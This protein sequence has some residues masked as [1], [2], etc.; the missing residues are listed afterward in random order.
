MKTGRLLHLVLLMTALAF[1][2]GCGGGSSNG[3]TPPPG[4]TLGI[5]TDAVLPG[6][7]SG[8]S[9]SATLSAS[10]GVG[11]LHWSIA[12]VSSTALYVTGLTIDAN[13]GKLSG[14]VNWGGTAGFIA[15]VTDSS[16]TARTA[17]KGFYITAY[18]PLQTPAPQNATVMEYRDVFP[19]TFSVQGGVAPLKF[20]LTGGSLPP[21]LRLDPGNGGQILG[22][23]ITTGTYP[24]TVTIQ[25]SF[26]PPEV[27]TMQLTVTVIPPALTIAGGSLPATMALNRAFSGKV[28][29]VGGIPPYHFALTAGSL[30][31]GLGT[32]D[33]GGFISGIPN[34][35]GS[36]AFTVQA[37]DSANPVQSASAY[38]AI[39][40]RP[41][42]GRND[43]IATATPIDNGT[44]N[45]SISP[46]ID[47]PIGVPVAGD[48]DYYSL[49]ALGGTTV[50]VET[51]A[52]RWNQSNP[53]D[54]VLEIL[55]ANGAR[56]NTCK[57]PGDTGT[58]YASSCINDDISASP[59]VQDSALDLKVPGASNAGTRFYVHVLDWRGDARPD[60][61]YALTVSGVVAPLAVQTTSLAPAARGLSYSQQ[62][63]SVNGTG[64][65]TWAVI[66][67]ALPPGLSLSSAG[68]IT[69]SATTDGS[70]AFTVQATDSANP[71]QTA[72]T[73]ESI[74]VVEPVK[75]TSSPTLPDACVN[76]AYS[77]AI[78]TSGG[79]PPLQWSF[80]S[81]NWVAIN[82]NQA[83]GV[84]SGTTNVAG[85]FI[86]TLG[87]GDATGH[88]DSQ[89]I[90]LTVKQCP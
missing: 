31:P 39:T 5:T 52:K 46:Y 82:L 6:T 80:M 69:G 38:F 50:H 13:T 63:S 28:I 3:T 86:G 32:M 2:A 90:S 19:L 76:Q 89:Q 36:Y 33:S 44:I 57:Q 54:T 48:N 77:F 78:Q 56:L 15:T 67:G 74:L 17:T 55:D 71:P 23:A 25:D 53:L 84:F 81:S 21:G 49:L 14:T 30:P 61:S 75:I 60:M 72:T 45:A 8:R 85:T 22:S 20:A 59:H 88:A 66:T 70:Y 40:V 4:Q 26:S 87:V 10:G 24:S 51:F 73:N 27:V 18:D 7:L 68:A 64:S 1:V 43:T 16:S 11:A 34:I 79:V 47:P 41:P 62:L 83:T 58:T 12:P 9:Y 29:A 37:M 42:L 35:A 65:V